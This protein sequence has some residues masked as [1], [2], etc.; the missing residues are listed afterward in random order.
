MSKDIA[1]Q[2]KDILFKFL[3]EFYQDTALNVFGLTEVPRIKQL[4][5]NHFPAVKAEEKRSDTLFLLE[6]DSILMLEFESNERTL[7]NHLKYLE[8]AYQIL[9]RD[10]HQERKIRNIQ[11]VVIYTSDVVSAKSGLSA[12][13]VQL[14]SK[15]VFLHE[16]NG[17][18]IFE[19]IKGKIANNELL[20]HEDLMKLNFLPLMYSRRERKELIHD[21]IELAK[22]IHDES[23]QVQVI[24]GILTATDKF[25]DK[26][27]AEKVRE[28]LKMTQVGR[29][30]DEEKQEA[31][32]E[33]VKKQKIEIAKSLL[34]I[35]S[36]VEVAKRIELDLEEV[37]KLQ[38]N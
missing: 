15:A 27:Y 10:F 8:Y 12:G 20:T 33:A 9:K 23:T 30:F 11:I 6:D 21:S 13:D 4:L 36:P 16:Y 37:K 35:L 18:A 28:W 24:A 34:E 32:K 29:L 17:D 7:E 3:S 31:V 5:P 19:N 2:N 25:I 14:N 26:N 22:H 1:Y 38:Q